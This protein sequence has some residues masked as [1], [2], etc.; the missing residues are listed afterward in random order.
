M[1]R[2]VH[3]PTLRRAGASGEIV[4]RFDSGFGPSRPS[5]RWKRLDVRYTMAVRTNTKGI[6]AAIAAMDPDAWVDIDYPPDGVAQVAAAPTATD[7]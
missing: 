7:A 3:V 6:A 2:P 5:P 4:M 1:N